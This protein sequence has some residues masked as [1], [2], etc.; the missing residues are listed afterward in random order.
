MSRFL[1]ISNTVPLQLDNYCL[2]GI[3]LSHIEYVE[4]ILLYC[5]S[6]KLKKVLM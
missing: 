5:L 2:N 1:V 6:L 3:R 4:Y